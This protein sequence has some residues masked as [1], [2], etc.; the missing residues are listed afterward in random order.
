MSKN[1]LE[2]CELSAIGAGHMGDEHTPDEFPTD[3]RWQ[4][5]WEGAYYAGK[6][7]AYARVADEIVGKCVDRDFPSVGMHMDEYEKGKEVI[8]RG[9][10][11][12]A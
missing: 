9:D 6:R 3:V 5:I 4:D 1:I 2:F 7:D 8:A 11:D 12:N 10:L